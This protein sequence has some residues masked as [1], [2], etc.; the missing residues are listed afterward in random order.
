M[1]VLVEEGR[2]VVVLFCSGL[3][4]FDLDVL[5]WGE[6]KVWSTESLGVHAVFKYLT[7]FM[8]PQGLPQKKVKFCSLLLAYHGGPSVPPFTLRRICLS[9]LKC[10]QTP[11]FAFEQLE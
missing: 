11:Q 7:K 5:A 4:M 10:G 9:Q 8:K 1:G 2:C 6:G 3:G